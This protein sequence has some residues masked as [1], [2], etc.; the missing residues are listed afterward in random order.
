MR[1]ISMAQALNEA[2]FHC[3]EEDERVCVLGEG[4]SAPRRPECARSLK[5]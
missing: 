3:M 1:E 4:A 2:L 5:S